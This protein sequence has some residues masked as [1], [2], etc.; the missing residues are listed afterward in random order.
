MAMNSTKLA[1]GL[2][3]DIFLVSFGDGFS[4]SLTSWI[5]I[6]SSKLRR[7]S[8]DSRPS[9]SYPAS[10]V[11]GVLFDSNLFSIGEISTTSVFFLTGLFFCSLFTL[12]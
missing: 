12:V 5:F 10:E 1:R 3:D 7:F 6:G 11:K 9:I 2:D 8:S 4:G